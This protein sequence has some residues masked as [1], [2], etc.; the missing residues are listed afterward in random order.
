MLL[1]PTRSG[2]PHGH[3]LRRLQSL[4]LKAGLNCGE[5]VNKKGLECSEEPVCSV[6]GL[7][8]FRRTFATMHSEAGVSA[9]TIQKW[10]GHSDLSTTLRYLAVA[11]MRS[12]R[13][14]MQVNASFAAL[15]ARDVA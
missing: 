3:M 5:C 6:W 10:L 13:T 4:A 15:P 12:E 1:F 8:K 7:H 9:R 14:R 2:K 11:D